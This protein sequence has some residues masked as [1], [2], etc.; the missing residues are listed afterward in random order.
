MQQSITL[1]FL[2]LDE[3]SLFMVFI[4]VFIMFVSYL[5]AFSFSNIFTLT[6]VIS[7][8]YFFCFIVFSV[9]NMFILYT[10]YEASLLPILFIIIK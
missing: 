3:V 10:S 8:M 4:T 9:D 5:V 7:F 1:R 6:L 2:T